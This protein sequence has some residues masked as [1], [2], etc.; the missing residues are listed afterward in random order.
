MAT[1][2][3]KQLLRTISIA[4]FL[5]GSNGLAVMELMESGCTLDILLKSTEFAADDIEV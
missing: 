2:K 4:V 5:L 3:V 1:I